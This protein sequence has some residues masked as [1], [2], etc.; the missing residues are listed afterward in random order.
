MF[1]AGP[2]RLPL[3]PMVPLHHKASGTRSWR[4][5]KEATLPKYQVQAL[6]GYGGMAGVYL[7]FEPKLGRDV[8]IKV[9]APNLML[10]ES[11]VSRFVQEA[12]TTA[13]LNH[14]NIVTIFD[15]EH[16]DKL[17]YFAMTYVPGKTL[18]EVMQSE[19]RLG[20][21]AVAT[22][23]SQVAAALDY[24]DQR[25]VVHRDIKPGNILLDLHGN[26]LVTDFGIAKVASEPSLTRTGMLVGTPAYMS[27]EQCAGEETTSAS[28]QYA[29][30]CVAYRMITGQTPFTGADML[31]MQSHMSEPVAPISELR[32]DVPAELAETV[33]RMLAKKPEDRWPHLADVIDQLSDFVP[34]RRDPAREQLIEMGLRVSNLT[35]ASPSEPLV[36]GTPVPMVVTPHDVRGQVLSNRKIE[37]QSS[38]PSVVEVTDAGTLTAL[39][40]GSAKITALC[41]GVTRSAV[42]EVAPVEISSLQLELGGEPAYR[43]RS[44]T[45]DSD[46]DCS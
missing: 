22:W 38:D 23:V 31:V 19:G 17:S 43:R 42:L 36:P 16:S 25:G 12:R 32:D 35:I 24:A 8:A 6:L 27:P 18:R 45:P 40:A 29:L 44:H 30:G 21:P 39:R 9:M 41:E 4:T 13:Q 37:W 14:P 10:D 33:Q 7:A 46:A 26:A 3:R 11:L 5:L 1:T 28:D 15:V 20:I 2:L 34:N